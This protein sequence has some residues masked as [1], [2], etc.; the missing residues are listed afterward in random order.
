VL[1]EPKHTSI[2][3]GAGKS[4][5]VSSW[6]MWSATTSPQGVTAP[7]I[8]CGRLDGPSPFT[9]SLYPGKRAAIDIPPD[10]KGKIALIE[11]T[12]QKR[13]IDAMFKGHIQLHNPEA[14]G[15]HW[16]LGPN[17][18]NVPLAPADLET[19]LRDA[20]ALAVIYAWT[21]ISDDE[22][23]LELKRGGSPVMAALCV[24]PTA[25]GALRKLADQ[26]ESVTFTND[27]KIT[28]HVQT[29][30]I[31]ATLPGSSD[32]EALILWTHSDGMNAI[33]ENG[34]IAIVNLMR[35]FSRLPVSARKRSIVCVIAD[36]HFAE[37]YSPSLAWMTERPD[38]KAKAVACVAIEHLGCR[39]WQS[40][41]ATNTFAP[42][43]LPELMFAFCSNEPMPQLAQDAVA[44]C[45]KGLTA[46]VSTT[47]RGFSPALNTYRLGKIP[48]IACIAAPSYLLSEGANGHLEKLSSALFYDQ[49][50]MFGRMI[51]QLDETPKSALVAT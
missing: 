33:E 44:G 35:Y 26:G 39:E 7:L 31:V 24:G 16:V 21:N 6:V 43:G 36:G 42:T 2:V 23:Y 47:E 17:A 41:P 12:A 20:G 8:Y 49:V 28:E 10:V 37:Q 27:A 19:K 5:P 22:A 48:T 25:G 38:I 14:D 18:T 34:G 51:H 29:R 30:T 13:P 46:V 9:A 15:V 50:K 40:D 1:W 4:Y 45:A 3:D 32:D 11:L